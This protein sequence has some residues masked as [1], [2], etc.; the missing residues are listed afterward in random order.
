[1]ICNKICYIDTSSLFKRYIEEK[2]T[3][4]LDDLF[5]S[6]DDIYVSS[7]TIVEVISNLKRLFEVD[8][9]IDKK[10]FNALKGCF[11]NDIANNTI[12]LEPVFPKT[13]IS[14]VELIEYKYLTPIDSIQLA[15]ALQIV[16]R[17]SELVFVCSD[18]KLISAAKI[19]GLNVIEI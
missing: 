11:M 5:K 10:T 3:Q 6:T 19:K 2:G 17:S 7:L 9:L 12:K 13:I 15:T 8:K 4:A 14:A 1:M 16:A 18:F